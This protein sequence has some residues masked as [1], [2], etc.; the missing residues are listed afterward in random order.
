MNLN[1]PIYSLQHTVR[2]GDTVTLNPQ[3]LPPRWGDS[4]SINP[5]PLPPSVQ[6]LAVFG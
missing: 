4:V 1:I 5:Q 3:P 6:G 2:P